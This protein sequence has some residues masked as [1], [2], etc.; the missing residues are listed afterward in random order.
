MRLGVGKAIGSATRAVLATL[1]AAC[2][3]QLGCSGDDV[4][5]RAPA[6]GG[7]G[8]SAGG[9]AGSAASA[10]LS[11]GGTSVASGGT[12]GVQG[13]ATGTGGAIPVACN[14]RGFA[15]EFDGVD[16]QVTMGA[17]PSLGLSQWTLE[18]WMKRTGPGQSTSTGPGGIGVIPLIAKGRGEADGDPRDCNYILGIRPTDGVLVADFEEMATGGNHPIAG[19]T[20]VSQNYWHHVAATYD[21]TT[22][23]L[24]LDGALEATL[25]V[26]AS[27]RSDSI[28]HFGLGAALNSMGVASGFFQGAL[29]EVRVW[30]TARSLAEIQSGMSAK[31]PSATGLVGRWGLDEGSG[32]QAGDSVAGVNG[33]ISGATF[34]MGSPFALVQP[35]SP[36]LVAPSESATGV[37]TT[38]P[39]SVTV[40]DPDSATH[41]VRFFGRKYVP[42]DDFTIVV[43][44]D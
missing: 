43:F 23:Q 41:D 2:L 32:T 31:I 35:P 33:T 42:S 10:G 9:S 21:G 17:A 25:A 13:G 11:A 14:A 44:P 26:N 24:Y 1:L 8:S 20:V 27:P 15:L 22:W 4:A 6:A 16:D 19:T 30:N 28:Q 29:D 3:T 18:A 12:A 36:T 7:A 37:A 40:T 39:V 38:T 5:D 34:V